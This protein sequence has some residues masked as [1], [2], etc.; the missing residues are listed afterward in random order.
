MEL[1]NE[2]GQ[3]IDSHGGWNS[4]YTIRTDQLS[5]GV[6]Y[7]RVTGRFGDMESRKFAI[8]H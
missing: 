8:T 3:R 5:G 4:G 2:M 6:Y 1:F 7:I